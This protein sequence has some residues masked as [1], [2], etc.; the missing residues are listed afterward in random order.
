[1]ATNPRFPD[2]PRSDDR[3]LNADLRRNAPKGG[4]PWILIALIVAAGILA[5]IIIWMPRTPKPSMPTNA[6]EVPPQ[7]TGQQIQFTGAKLVPSPTGNE[8]ALDAMMSN[9]SNTSV[10]GV[11]V[12]GQFVGQNGR[13]TSIPAKVML[14]DPSSG[15]TTDLVQQ[16]I[17]ANAQKP[18]RIV[19]DN[20]PQDWNHTV[21]GLTVTAVTA[22]GNSGGIGAQ[23]TPRE[24]ERGQTKNGQPQNQQQAPPP[25]P[26]KP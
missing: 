25:A 26:R 12:T 15:A 13:P 9:V 14:L 4:F 2:P 18:V 1:M 8:I 17:P 11:A 6:A 21:P 3:K 19:F 16:P 24:R 10:T 5:A 20:V 22:V 7:P 23:P